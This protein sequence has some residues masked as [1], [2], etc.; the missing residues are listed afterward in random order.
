MSIQSEINRILH[1][2]DQSF[3]EVRNK[4]VTV[5]QDAI[6]DDL[7]DYIAQIQTGSGGT[8]AIS[9]VDTPDAAG[10]TVRTITAVDISDTTAVAGDVAQGKYFYAA[11][12]TKTAG[13]ASGGGGLEY[14]KGTWTPAADTTTQ[15]ISFA[16]THTDLPFFMCVMLAS[17]EHDGELNSGLVLAYEN[18]QTLF[19]VPIYSSDSSINCGYVR[20]VYRATNATGVSTGGQT[21]ST[22][23]TDTSQSQATKP[24]YWVRNDEF[25]AY[26]GNASAYW[27]SGKT[28]N[29][30]AVWAPTS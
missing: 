25:T 28:Y 18:W 27:R 13:T 5:P 23:D 14:E 24:R 16:K 4:G 30:V 29:W 21:I 6:I 22:L 8:G 26:T 2:R 11:D 20:Y 7:P 12:G 15:V 10:G 19:G 9:I 17:G 3:E 1:F